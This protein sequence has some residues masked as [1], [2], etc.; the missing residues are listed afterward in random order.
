MLEAV[1][2]IPGMLMLAMLV[3]QVGLIWHGT[4]VAQAAAQEG[5]LTASGFDASPEA[6]ERAA[7]S[8][9]K[10]VAPRLLNAPT[11]H[12]DQT[13]TTVTVTVQAD[14]LALPLLSFVAPTHVVEQARGPREVFVAP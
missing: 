3:I 12:A 6:G 4:N 11:V 13:P 2:V 5:L 1:L 9:L 8:Y 14:V 7:R 10:D